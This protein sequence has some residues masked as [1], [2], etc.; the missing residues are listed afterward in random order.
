MSEHKPMSMLA[1]E[2]SLRRETLIAK[3]RAERMLLTQHSKQLRRSLLLA[4]TGLQLLAKIRQ[5]PA[6]GIGLL[7]ASIIIKPRR[8]LSIL[9]N[10]L[11]GW[12]IWQS[13]APAFKHAQADTRLTGK[14][15]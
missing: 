3:S 2:L 13:V 15:D 8:I 1:E 14:R 9:K 7:A 4:D 11:L 5:R 10:G 12:Q 6:I